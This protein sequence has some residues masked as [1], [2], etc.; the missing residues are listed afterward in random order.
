MVQPLTL[1]TILQAE[2]GYVF[3]VE[4]PEARGTAALNLVVQTSSP[5]ARRQLQTAIESTAHTLRLLSGLD[6]EVVPGH[7]HPAPDPLRQ[8]GR[9]MHDLLLPLPIQSFLGGLTRHTPLLISTNDSFLPWELVH[10]GAEFLALKCPLGRRL[11]S[12]ELVR[13]NPYEPHAGK[14]FMLIA[15]PTGDLPKADQEIAALTD[16]LDALPEWSKYEVLAR[17]GATKPEV[18]NCLAAGHWDLIHYSGHVALDESR[19]QAISLC[20]ANGEVLTAEEI[21]RA[22]RGRPLIFLNGCSSGKEQ[23]GGSIEPGNTEGL[24]PYPGLPVQGLVSAFLQGG[25]MGFIGTLWP[26]YDEAAYH[27]ALRF[28]RLALRGEPVG[29]ALREAR[30]AIRREHP[31]DPIW[32]S[33]VFYGDPT[34]RIADFTGQER[35]L[36]TSLYA[37]LGGLAE[38]FRSTNLEE[39][40]NLQEA[41]LKLLA[42][43]IAAY[44]GQVNSLSHAGLEATFGA[45]LAY[46]DDAQQAVW[47]A[48]AMQQ[49]WE[50]FNRDVTRRIGTS[51]RLSL[52][53]STGQ[54][55]T[56]ETTSGERVEYTVRGEAVDQAVR[57]GEQVPAGQVWAEEHTY[58]LVNRAFDFVLLEQAPPD[59]GQTIYRLGGP[60]P[61]RPDAIAR[62][63]PFVGRQEQLATLL[64]CWQKALHGE[65]AL[66]TITGVA[67]VGKSRLVETWRAGLTEAPCRWIVGICQPQTS[68]V[69]YGLLSAVLRQLFGLEV[70]DDKATAPARI[71]AT[72]DRLARAQGPSAATHVNLAL[73]LL[74]DAMGLELATVPAGDLDAGA[75]HSQLARV[76]RGLLAQETVETP[77]VIILE[78]IHWVDEASLTVIDRL[79]E[80]IA[81]LPVLLIALC[82]LPWQYSW[83]ARINHEIVV[84]HLTDDESRELLCDLLETPAVPPGLADTVLSTA[85]GSPLFLKEMVRALVETGALV[86]SN[87][88]WRATERLKTAQIPATIQATLQARVDRLG[89]NEQRLLH[90]ASVLGLEFSYRVLSA[91]AESFEGLDVDNGLDVLCR[92]EFVVERTLWPEMHYAFHHALIQ[93]VAYES[94]VAKERK[95]LHRL[96]GQALEALYAGEEQ[97]AHVEGLAYHFYEGEAWAPA[98]GYQSRVGEKALALFAHETARGYFERA[99]ALIESG[100][101]EPNHKQRLTCF[102]SL[103]DIYSVQGR[104]EAARENYQ[105]A[106]DLPGVGEAAAADLG[107]KMAQTYERQGQFDLALEWLRRGLAGRR[108]QPDDAITARLY[109]LQGIIDARQGRLDQ[110]FVG[111][112]R[113]LRAIEGADELAEEAQASNL[114]G[115]LYRSRGQ[116]DKAAECCRRSAELYES[117][118][119]PLKAAAAY[120]NLGV[121]AFERDDW[122]GA[123]MAYRQSLKLQESTDDAYG[124]STTHCNLADLLWR[125]GRL[126]EALTHAQTGLR[127]A[128]ELDADYVRALAHL[129]LGAIY[130]RRG[131]SEQI[132]REHLEISWRLLEKGDVHELR[133]EVQSLL[134]EAYLREARIDEAEH[135]ARRALKIALE[136]ES[137]LD[138]EM[139]RRILD[140]VHQARGNQKAGADPGQGTGREA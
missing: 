76:I 128:S 83:T 5:Q 13:C 114:L 52:A 30:E 123:E 55:I 42:Q 26:V 46:G 39:A 126:E 36:V 118:H 90:M 108:D 121:V 94:L 51:L 43:E 58:R 38:L 47:A 15:D 48:W 18:L 63:S 92:Q 40:A 86:R 50:R 101:L 41:G 19:S 91:M 53:L 67:G 11:L 72:V 99:K 35:R 75:R 102:E 74:G 62:A 100:R 131:E 105:T 23:V 66:I 135:A 27:F 119:N 116:L 64:Q 7:S 111:A 71:K 89:Q 136:Q 133:S 33:F 56:G 61:Q 1:L 14:N 132:V 81:H 125:L 8:L 103:G 73:A 44:G 17:Q 84:D 59:W 65:G 80:G 140:Q 129:N 34:W 96:A 138:E 57:L 10:D 93:Q 115:V 21:R 87:G 122:P 109:L 37:R 28:Y 117:I 22:V 20:L 82:R 95:R 9:L 45:P 104:F 70:P 6:R 24:L 25:A 12:T 29:G 113:A 110:A 4:S 85:G 120:S 127:L 54:A 78:D 60:K 112:E 88:S 31:A 139:A 124:Q 137:S 2:Q 49:A 79:A 32:A 130:L 3:Q 77:L 106:L 107:R 69:P 68:G 134:A 97:G 16:L 98:L